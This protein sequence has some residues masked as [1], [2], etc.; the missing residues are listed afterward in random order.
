MKKL[1]A[2]VLSGVMLSSVVLCGC[3][4][5]PK[6]TDADEDPEVTEVETEDIVSPYDSGSS[7]DKEKFQEAIELYNKKEPEGKHFVAVYADEIRGDGS[8]LVTDEQISFYYS[9]DEGRATLHFTYMPKMGSFN[10]DIDMSYDETRY[11]LNSND[12]LSF[13]GLEA[14]IDD[15]AALKTDKYRVYDDSAVAEHADQIK[16]D[17]PIYYSR[18]IALADKAFPELGYG[19]E[20]L[21]FKLGDK[22]RALDPVQ[23]SSTEPVIKNEHKF[24]NGV[25]TDCG[26]SWT[27]YYYETL[28]KMDPQSKPGEWHSIYGQESYSMIG[29]GDYVQLSA[30]DK[31][32][33]TIY[34]QHVEEN[35]NTKTCKI[36]VVDRGGKIGISVRFNYNEGMYSVGNGIVSDKFTYSFD[37]DVDAGEFDKVFESKEAF[38]KNCQMYLFVQDEDRVGHDVWSS[39]SDDEIKKIF[40]EVEGCVYYNKEEMTDMF[41]EDC[42]RML[43]SMDNAMRWMDTCLADA[44]INWKKKAE[45]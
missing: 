37:L 10:C 44:G 16:N 22:Y 31:E 7:L 30:Y 3:N 28:E 40:D 36:Y 41:W 39:K 24:E 38:A 21:G 19:F 4:P 29:P 43:E 14:Y 1:I 12:A 18:M 2:V 42:Q 25:C 32:A 8:Y 13:D 34:Y 11:Y 5:K 33:S 17:L 9:A 45:N 23:A 27:E 6:D 26:M 35:W 15:A 20:E